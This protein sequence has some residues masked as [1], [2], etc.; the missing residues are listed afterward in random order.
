MIQQQK[1]LIFPD[2]LPLHKQLRLKRHY[3]ELSQ[4]ELAE[5]LGMGVSTLSEVENGRRRIPYKHLQNVKEYLF[6]ELV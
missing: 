4:P 3:D 6:K 1:V 2:S 5:K